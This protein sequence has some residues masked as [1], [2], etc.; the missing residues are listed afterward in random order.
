MNNLISSSLLV[1]VLLC[2]A[3]ISF[4]EQVTLKSALRSEPNVKPQS[5]AI[6]SKIFGS[7]IF[8]EIKQK[9]QGKKWL[10][11]LWSVDCPPCMKELAIVQALQ[12]QG[13][14]AIVIINVDTYEDSEQQRDKILAYFNLASQE[15][16][17]F[18]D[19]REDHSRYLIDPHWFGELPRSYFIDEAGT[20]HGKSGL[21]SKELLEEWLIVAQ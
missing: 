9:Y 19:G 16:L 6:S 8:E 7:A 14:L 12:Q 3:P 10:A 17:H 2:N 4:A 11:L 20:F 15:N 21:A 18:S 13:E 1:F 5:K